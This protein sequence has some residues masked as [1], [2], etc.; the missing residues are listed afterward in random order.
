MPIFLFLLTFVLAISVAADTANQ[1]SRDSVVDAFVG[2][3]HGGTSTDS[4]APDG[5]AMYGCA[6]IGS[7]ADGADSCAINVRF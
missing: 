7:S 5:M 6:S 2:H 1:A 4:N 3:L